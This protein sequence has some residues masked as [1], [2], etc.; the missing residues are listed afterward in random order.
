MLDMDSS[1]NIPI[2]RF[3]DDEG[4][5]YPEWYQRRV[6]DICDINP[7]SRNLPE[8]FTYIDLESVKKGKLL[9]KNRINR[10]DAPSRAQRV[11]RKQDVLIQTVRPYQQNNYHF[12]MDGNFVASTGYTQLRTSDSSRF[13]YDL[14]HVKQTLWK[15]LAAC[16]GTSYPAITSHDLGKIVVLY[17]VLEEQQKIANFLSSV[18]TRIEQLEKKKSLLEQY[19]KG[20]MQKLFSQEIRFKYDKGEEYPE[21][22]KVRLE[23]KLNYV[24]PTKYI[25]STTEYSDD[26][27]M[28]VLTAGKSFVLGYT[29][30]SEGVFQEMLPVI[31]FDD[32]T[33]A[34]KFVDFPFKVKSSAMKILYPKNNGNI[35]FVFEAMKTIRFPL[36]EH[37]RYWISE[38]SRERI[39]YPC[40]EEQQKI[41]IFLS[42]VDK[43]IELVYEQINQT[44]EFKKGLLQQMFV[45]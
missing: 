25:V 20:L 23:E 21:W 28:P 17:P 44:R 4:K 10:S 5:E 43:N 29:N 12:M 30:E 45:N 3:K 8:N 31:I 15:I 2:L 22:E 40:F 39:P 24:Q 32:F 11:L 14:L 6:E 38:F 9:S 18:D 27:E 42:S 33:T 26:F 37:K 36:G 34:F 41:T 35:R 19:K 13:L 16:T 1:K 7:N